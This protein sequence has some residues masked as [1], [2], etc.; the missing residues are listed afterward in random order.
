MTG[1]ARNSPNHA[2]SPGGTIS[3]KATALWFA[4]ISLGL[5]LFG[6]DEKPG[7]AA[8]SPP[9]STGAPS[10]AKTVEIAAKYP[11]PKRLVA[12]GDV[13]GDL[14]A[15]KRALRLAGA[16]DASDAWIGGDL[17]VVQTG[18]DIDRGDEDRAI[19]DLFDRLRDEA[20]AK[21]GMF[22]VLNGNHEL[23]NAALDFRYVTDGAKKTFDDLATDKR[24]G[25]PSV[26]EPDRGRANAFFPGGVYAKRLAERPIIAIVG[27]SVFVHGGVLLKHLD[28]GVDKMDGEVKRWLRGEAPLPDVVMAEDGPVWTR[29]YSAQPS[30]KECDELDKVLDRL[31]AKRM[32]MGHT[33][34]KPDINAACGDKAWRIDTGMSKYYAGNV[35]VLE[36]AGDAVKVLKESP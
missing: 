33:P 12:F 32:V 24:A 34:Q 23:M 11:A 9:P 31:G 2:A 3:V 17:V 30:K 35:E 21:G 15:T 8:G 4:T 14:D 25:V 6:C 26:A 16:I 22:L 18:D 36:I 5:C 27:D 13:H 20:K 1:Y 29:N 7:A 10:A 19:L 28:Y